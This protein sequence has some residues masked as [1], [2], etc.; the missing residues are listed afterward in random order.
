MVGGMEYQLGR[1]WF[2]YS[3]SEYPNSIDN[4]K[5]VR[6][7]K[8]VMYK[9]GGIIIFFVVIRDVFKIKSMKLKFDI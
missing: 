2:N 8:N 7:I 5:R 9:V 3:I 1:V 6:M 4:I